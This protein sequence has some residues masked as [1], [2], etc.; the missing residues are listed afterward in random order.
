MGRC[1]NNVEEKQY[2]DNSLLEDFGPL[3]FVPFRHSGGVTHT[4]FKQHLLVH[5]FVYDAPIYDA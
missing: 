5:V 1:K 3:D 4:K 2:I